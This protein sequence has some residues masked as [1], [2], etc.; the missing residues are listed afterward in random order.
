MYALDSF[1]SIVNLIYGGGDCFGVPLS[2]FI[3]KKKSIVNL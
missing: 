3:K 1:S 2:L